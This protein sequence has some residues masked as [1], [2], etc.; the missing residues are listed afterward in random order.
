MQQNPYMNNSFD[1]QMHPGVVDS[2]T[3]K[4]QMVDMCKQYHHHFIQ[5][6]GTDGNL[7]DGIL[8]GTDKNNVYMLVP[9]G[10]MDDDDQMNRQ[11]YPYGGYPH[12]GYGY[13]RRFRRFRRHRF[14]FFFIRNLFFPYFY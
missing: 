2:D 4:N 1:G 5:L 11:F 14:P 12:Y 3:R 8:D 7:Y 9:D 13:P 6:E 10:D